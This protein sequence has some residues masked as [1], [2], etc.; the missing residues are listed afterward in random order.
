MLRQIR[1]RNILWDQSSRT[2]ALNIRLRSAQ[3]ESS[4]TSERRPGAFAQSM[5]ASH[6]KLA[7]V[8]DGV[9]VMAEHPVKSV[10]L[11]NG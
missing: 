2:A 4:G 8:F 7:K 11:G 6:N 5:L 3:R 10:S 9:P 1:D